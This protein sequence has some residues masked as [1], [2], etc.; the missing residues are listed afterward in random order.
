MDHMNQVL[1][2]LCTIHEITRKVKP[3][4]QKK[5]QRSHRFSQVKKMDVVSNLSLCIKASRMQ[6]ELSN[7]WES[8]S[9]VAR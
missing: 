1:M 5:H 3:N 2:S 6:L 9:P 8:P 4:N 7:P